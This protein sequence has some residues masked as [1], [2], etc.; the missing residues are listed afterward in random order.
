MKKTVILGVIAALVLTPNISFAQKVFKENQIDRIVSKMT[1]EEKAKLCVGQMFKNDRV[2]TFT[3]ELSNYSIPSTMVSDGPV[4]LH[5]MEPM[6]SRNGKFDCTAFPIT[7]AVASSWNVDLAEEMG[8]ALTDECKNYMCDVIL[9]PAMNILRN[10]LCGRNFEYIS[11]DPLASGKM[12]AAITRGL[13][14]GGIGVSLKHFAGNNQETNRSA[15]DARMTA[16]ALREIYLKGF[17]IA[18][19]ESDPWTIMTSYNRVNG[20]WNCQ[21]RELL[22][23]ITRDEWGFD[24]VFMTDF[25]GGNDLAALVHA[26]NDLVMPGG[27]GKWKQIVAAVEDGRLAEEDLDA[28]C[29]RILKYITRTYVYK[30]KGV[31]P[32]YPVDLKA[33]AQKS[34]KVALESMVLMQNDNQALPLASDSKVSL[35][36]VFSYDTYSTGTGAARVNTDYKVNIIDGL[37]NENVALNTELSDYYS[38]YVAEDIA[39][40][41]KAFGPLAAPVVAREIVPSIDMIRRA[42]ANSDVAVITIGRTAGEG[43]DRN[44]KAGDWYL[45]DVES[46]LLAKVSAAFRSQGKKVVVVLNSGGVIETASWK[47]SADAILN[48]WQSGLEVGNAVAQLLTGKANPSGKLSVT[49]PNSYFDLPS[50]WNFPYDYE[51]PKIDPEMLKAQFEAMEKAKANNE[52]M[53]GKS[54]DTAAPTFVMN[55]G[56]AGK[57]ADVRNID[58]T[59]YEDDIYV[60]YRYFTTAGVGTS[61]PFGS[62]L[63]YTTFEYSRPSVTKTAEG[64]EAKVTVTNTGKVAGKEVV[65]LYVS[66]PQT[67][68]KPKYELRG[69]AKT[70]ELAPGQ[71]ETLTITFTA[72]D[73]ASFHEDLSAWVTDKGQY[74][75][76]FAASSEDIRQQA[77][78]TVDQEETVKTNRAVLPQEKINT[79]SLR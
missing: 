15:N 43:E 18:V 59:L 20:F 49:Y 76:L 55:A 31:Y 27:D 24:G 75:A 34:L 28:C 4:G 17:E 72:Y 11:E 71:S 12:A 61:F 39:S 53:P 54:D 3:R 21:N 51:A 6:P 9:G 74:T 45:S 8:Y 35:F 63:S 32:S 52:E 56:A 65:Q 79:L 13:Q 30:N 47:H 67:I 50:S 78:F 60:G 66:A 38:K 19:K 62:G 70:Q 48:A 77:G 46:E 22:Q 42:A 16:R 64:Y 26:G 40:Q 14:K 41:P 29:K 44:L 2:G 57:K 58:Y 36:G 10:P 73:L 25:G 23:T 69:F 7:S 5:I 1:V 37:R 68:E 33:N